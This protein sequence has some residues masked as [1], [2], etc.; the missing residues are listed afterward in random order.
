FGLRSAAPTRRVES[1]STTDGFGRTTTGC[2]CEPDGTVGVVDRH[3]EVAENVGARGTLHL[4]VGQLRNGAMKIGVG[5]FGEPDWADDPARDLHRRHPDYARGMVF[6]EQIVTR[7]DHRPARMLSMP[8]FQHG[9]GDVGGNAHAVDCWC[10]ACR[11][12]RFRGLARRARVQQQVKRLAGD[13]YAQ[14]CEAG[15]P[16]SGVVA[17]VAEGGPV[18]AGIRLPV[19]RFDP[20]LP[21]RIIKGPDMPRHVAGTNDSVLAGDF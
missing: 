1:R 12:T 5:A 19:S 10:L 13:L 8:S 4:S 2:A 21:C 18:H 3:H 15:T 11:F 20:Q 9:R 6:S 7:L 14:T 17:L 16:T